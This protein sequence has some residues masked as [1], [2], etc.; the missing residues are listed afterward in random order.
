MNNLNK[1]VLD[2]ESALEDVVPNSLNEET[3]FRFD[4]ESWD[5]LAALSVLAMIDSEYNLQVT[6][7]EFLKCTTI[8]DVFELITSKQ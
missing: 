2:F 8:K 1:F 3:K 6:A 5:S 4:I 7:E